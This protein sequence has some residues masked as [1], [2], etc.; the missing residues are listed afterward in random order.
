MQNRFFTANNNLLDAIARFNNI[1]SVTGEFL[2]KLLRD[3]C[4]QMG[5]EDHQINTFIKQVIINWQSNPHLQSGN[6][7]R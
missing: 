3:T 1:S 7:L 6:Q 5:W 4:T 2:I